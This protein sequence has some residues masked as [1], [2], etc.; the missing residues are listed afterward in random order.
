MFRKSTVTFYADESAEGLPEIYP[1]YKN[2][3]EWFVKSNTKSKCP[4]APLMNLRNIG[5]KDYLDMGASP[6]Q[7]TKVTTVKH[8]PGIVDYLK[9][10]YIMPAWSDLI[11]RKINGKI[12]CTSSVESP[13][14]EFNVHKPN[15][16]SGMDKDQ[17]PMMDVFNKVSSPW[18]IKTTPGTSVLI[19][20]PYWERNSIF[21]S[22]SAIVHP[23]VVPIH[24]KWFFEF[25]LKLK[26]SPEIYDE[27]EQIILKG[28]PLALIIPFKR[29]KFKH[30]TKFL[31]KSNIGRIHRHNYYN[32]TSWFSDSLYESFRK[33]LGN[34]Y[35]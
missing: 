3:P 16:F 7:L 14:F 13:E 12:H 4:F 23:D 21:T 15:Q 10:G 8:C 24:L 19:T 17:S 1:A 22:V 25:N 34:L 26:E 28:T 27:K 31:D 30:E 18:W 9:T 20:H 35:K 6:Y 29:E 32:S 5:A 2:F 33:K 11:F